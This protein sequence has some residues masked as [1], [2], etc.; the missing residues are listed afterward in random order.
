MLKVLIVEDEAL[1]AEKL[2]MLLKAID[3]S[4][5]VLA[6]LASVERAVQW[7]TN[8]QADLI[9]LDIHLSD[10]VS[11]KIFERIEVHTPIIFTTAYDQFAIKA[12]EQN[13]VAY[14]L[15]P[16]DRNELEKALN[17]YHRLT[18]TSP[19]APLNQQAME[20]LLGQLM[21]QQQPTTPQP[22]H[23]QRIMVS[24]G[25]NMRSI[26]IAQVA[27]F[28]AH[29]K[30][31]YLVNQAN[32][33]YIVDET[34]EKLEAERNPRQFFRVNRKYLINITA[35]KEVKALSNRKL[36]V[37]LHATTPDKV[38]VPTEK[39]TRFKQWLNS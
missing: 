15:K 25:G 16:V 21:H 1:A 6:V 27:V 23:K 11:F 29:E 20:Q 14:L 22:N 17:K 10:G 37:L 12:F 26:D 35:V 28:Y 9:F 19:T 39:I 24:Y 36:E 38:L 3:A 33:K 30:A 13:S 18:A 32:S 31:N 5:E 34:L 4:I 2:T 8:N 7:L